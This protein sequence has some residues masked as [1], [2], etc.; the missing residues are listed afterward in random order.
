MAISV[1]REEDSYKLTI[2]NGTAPLSQA[3][4]L[5]I[6]IGATV[7]VILLLF[8]LAIKLLLIRHRR[9]MAD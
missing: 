8:V 5:S 4:S 7:V 6:T 2:G 9:L 3:I 1:D